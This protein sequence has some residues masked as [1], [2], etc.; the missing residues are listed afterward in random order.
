MIHNWHVSSDGN[1]AVIRVVLFD[2]CK[3]FDFI[4]HN[5]LVRKLL[6][7]DI[8]NHILC[9][10][11]DFLSDRR[12]RVKL[13]E[14]CF[15]E[16]RYIPAGVPQRTKLGPWLFLIMIN[17]LNAGEAEMWKY[18]DD[19][20]IS[21]VIAKGQESCIQQMVDDLAIQARDEGF[22]LN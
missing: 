16:W 1:S 22:Q 17:D 13:S 12:Q 9:W 14:D 10:I 3:A 19:T 18:V 15:S 2:L 6:D 20:T 11:V 7:Y 5:I 4:D 21:E 8:L